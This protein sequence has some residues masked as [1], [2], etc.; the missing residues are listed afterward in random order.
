MATNEVTETQMANAREFTKSLSTIGFD[1]DGVFWVYDKEDERQVLLV[2]TDFFDVKGP[3]EIYRQ[4]FKAYN[5]SLTPKEIDPSCVR[6]LSRNQTVAKD[7]MDS[8]L[9]N[10]RKTDYKK[11]YLEF[12]PLPSGTEKIVKITYYN[13]QDYNGPEV[14]IRPER[15]VMVKPQH[16]IRKNT[17]I[18]KKWKLFENKLNNL[19]AETEHYK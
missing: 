16:K 9:S 5:A 10:P 12:N 18:I 2:V 4:I 6:F 3:L 8:V 11:D 1:M 7:I 14:I 19:T 15:V 13:W 17:E